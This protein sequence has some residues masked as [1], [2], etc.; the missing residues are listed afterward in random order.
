MFMEN[1]YVASVISLRLKLSR[2]VCLAAASPQYL[3]TILFIWFDQWCGTVQY[4]TG[5]YAG[6]LTTVTRN[7]YIYKYMMRFL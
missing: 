7:E 4:G 1:K 6:F 3:V 2:A 5:H